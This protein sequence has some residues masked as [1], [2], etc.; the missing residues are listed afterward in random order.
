MGTSISSGGDGGDRAPWVSA[1][2]LAAQPHVRWHD[3]RRGYMVNRLAREAWTA[4]YRTVP[5][6][7]RPD[8]PIATA[9]RW[10]IAHGRAGVE[11]A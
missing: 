4:E 3:G 6:V 2:A 9:T 10:H 11:R 1:E 7:S 8:A 5:F